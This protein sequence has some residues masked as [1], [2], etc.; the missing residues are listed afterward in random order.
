[1]AKFANVTCPVSIWT[2][3]LASGF[4]EFSLQARDNDIEF[5]TSATQPLAT[6]RGMFLRRNEI[7]QWFENI[8]TADKI[9]A[10]PICPDDKPAVVIPQGKV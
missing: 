3:V 7:P 4:S 8:D 9:W 2:E 6:D 10:R 5:Q 1:M